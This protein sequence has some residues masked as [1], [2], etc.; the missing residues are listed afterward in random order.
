LIV[1]G[2][3]GF[4]VSLTGEGDLILGMAVVGATISY[5]LMAGSHILLRLKRPDLHRPYKTPGGIFTSSLAL[6]L[7]LV[8]MTGVYAFDPRA[9]NYTIVLFI[10]GAVYYFA[11]GKNHLVAKTADEE[12]SMVLD[13]ESV[14]DHES[15]EGLEPKPGNA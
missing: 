13:A 15:E 14:L 3:F 6:V 9:F 7:S 1:P 4:L 5:A 2:I 11:Y 10:V 8:A 12:L